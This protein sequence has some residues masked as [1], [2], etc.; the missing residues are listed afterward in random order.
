MTAVIAR[1]E[2]G[3]G[4]AAPRRLVAIAAVLSAMALVVL[5]A[6][7]A[8]IALPTIAHALQVSP[9][10]SILIVT[11]YQ[12]AL[13]M[14]LLPCGALGEKLGY[15][16]VF[17]G[18]V[19]LFAAAS[20]MCAL[21]PDFGWLVAARFVQGLGGAAVMALGVALLR[22]SVPSGQLGAAIG[23]NALTVALCSA[24]G[25]SLGAL[26][27]GHAGWPWIFAVNLPI[28]A[29]AWFAARALPSAAGGRRPFDLLSASLNALA[30]GAL[31]LAAEL[32]SIRPTAAAGLLVAGLAALAALV[33][34]EAP[35]A[36]PL[37]PIDLLKIQS[38][39]IAVIASVCCFAGQT[40]A[41]V[42]LP[43]HL[44]GLGL[45]PAEAGL[46]LTAWPLAVAAT[47]SLAARLSE[48]V[49]A[50]WLCAVGGAL[51][52]TGLAGLSASPGADPVQLLPF[53]ALCGCGFGLFQT[54]NNRSMFLAAPPERSGAAGGMQATARLTG[55]A[56]GAVLAAAIGVAPQLA[57]LFG[58]LLALAAGAVSV[59][60]G[61]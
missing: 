6:S 42:T 49:A 4:L 28:G 47:S 27:L 50:A 10:Q 34:R 21:A 29:L 43:F 32:V 38:V 12:A 53:L 8:N 40:L 19:A 2:A 25:P 20:V 16:P 35:K 39:R 56:A 55:Q 7:I 11:A 58:A 26:I 33:A 1:D 14:A 52:A 46:C 22:F 57:F 60:R 41:L 45:S 59:L 9:S 48:R 3:D 36:A 44:Q 18:G 23:W 5:D 37:A 15:R 24:A 51:L 17:A 13:V 61:R 30:F 54:P 31:I